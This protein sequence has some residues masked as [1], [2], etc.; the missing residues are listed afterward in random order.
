MFVYQNTVFTKPKKVREKWDYEKGKAKYGYF[1]ESYLIGNLDK[2]LIPAVQNNWDAVLC[3]TGLE[4]SGKT[5]LASAVARYCDPRFTLKN[6]VFTQEDLTKAIDTFPPGSSIVF[7]EAV[8]AAM[9]ADAATAAQN[10]L[11]KKFTTCRKKRLFIFLVI[12]SIFMLRKYFACL[13]TRA[14]IHTYSPDGVK[15]GSFKFYGYDTKRDLYVKGYRDFNMSYVQPDFIGS[16]VDTTGFFYHPDDYETKKDKLIKS[17]E[18]NYIQKKEEDK[19]GVRTKKVTFERDA[20]LFIAYQAMRHIYRS[21]NQDKD[22]SYQDFCDQ[23]QEK[24]GWPIRKNKI[25]TCFK[26]SSEFFKA[27]IEEEELKKRQF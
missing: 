15:R 26:S 2:Y 13:R 25:V 12:P 3:F 22:L 17:I 1:L 24:F 20:A 11:I 16:F 27:C 21:K 6:V 8:M 18:D 5:T 19:V 23:V 4:G 7:D 10:V 14:L 9:A